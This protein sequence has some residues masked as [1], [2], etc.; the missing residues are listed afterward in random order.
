MMKV[1]VL[2]VAERDDG[3]SSSYG[4]CGSDRLC[5]CGDNSDKDCGSGGKIIGW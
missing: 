1:E 5:G 3:G 2:E 4:D